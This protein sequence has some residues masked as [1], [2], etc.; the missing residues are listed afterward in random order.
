VGGSEPVGRALGRALRRAGCEPVA[1]TTAAEALAQAAA[2]PP[3]DIVLLDLDEPELAGLQRT[4]RRLRPA[5]KL[6]GCA[7][8]MGQPPAEDAARFGVD[9]VLHKPVDQYAL[10][11]VVAMAVRTPGPD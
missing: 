2:Q 6:V 10:A 3:F 8:N 4:V 11:A 1:A 7:T 5:A 9:Y